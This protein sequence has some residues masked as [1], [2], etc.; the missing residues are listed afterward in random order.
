MSLPAFVEL[1]RDQT[2][3]DY[4]PNKN[5]VPTVLAQVCRDYQHLNKLQQIAAEG[6]RVELTKDIPP[7]SHP[8]D[9]HGSA[10]ER[11]NI[12]RKND[13]KEQDAWRCLVLDADLISMWPEVF[14]SPF[15]IVDKAGGDPLT[16]GR[17]IHDLSF[18][19]GASINDF[20]DQDAIPQA[21][22]QHCD[23]V[24]SE[25]LR[26]KREHLD[27]KAKVIACTHY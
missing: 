16:I 13:R 21:N 2:A 25:I 17:T 1:V 5:M 10:T 26:I 23:A 3:T 20:T 15:G 6:V 19:E 27:A 7:Q 24:A 4:R 14:I 12:L 8:P 18:P 11:V 22:Y 9:N